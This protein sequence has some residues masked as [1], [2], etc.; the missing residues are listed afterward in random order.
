MRPRLITFDIFG[1]VLD[2]QRGLTEAL[3]AE[4][5][6]LHPGDFD[7]IVDAQGRIESGPFLPYREVTARSLVE[8]LGLD[9]AAADRIGEGVGRWPLFPDSADAMAKLNALA[10]CMAITN[11]DRAHGEEVR[12]RLSMSDW[13]CAEDVRLYKPNPAFWEAARARRGGTFDRGWWHVSAYADY[14][15]QTAGQLGL[16]TIF[17]ERP[18][19]RIGRAH[20]HVRDLAQLLALVESER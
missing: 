13:I 11:S 7:R 3:A 18:H 4:G 6:T 15:L 14:D 5:V 2:W 20:H 9:R 8:V 12:R 17:V 16:T 19:A 10:P 1:T